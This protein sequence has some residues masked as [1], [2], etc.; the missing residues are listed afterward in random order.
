MQLYSHLRIRLGHP[1]SA[2]LVFEHVVSAIGVG[3]H[4]RH[5]VPLVD[6]V[7]HHHALE[8]DLDYTTREI[9]GQHSRAAIPGYRTHAAKLS[10]MLV[11][12]RVY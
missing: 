8:I 2:S 9:G 7:R 10:R 5:R 6:P 3:I 11:N 12:A 1:T 4:P